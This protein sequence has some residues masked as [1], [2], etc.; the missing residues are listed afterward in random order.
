[1]K[2][3]NIII[4]IIILIIVILLAILTTFYF[5]E[6]GKYVYKIERVT[7]INYNIINKNERYG[8]I[9]RQGNIIVEPIYDIIQIPNPSKPIFICMSD[10]DTEAREYTIKVFNEKGEILYGEYNNIQAIPNETA[11]DGIPFEKT[12]LK[13]KM[14][15]KYGIISIDGK[16]ITEPIYDQIS[17]ISYK[18]GM[19]LVEQNETLGVINING[20]TL[21]PVEY[22]SITTDNY[23]SE[24]T[25]YQT[26]GFI[27]SQ[28][29]EDGY[30][31]GYI[32]YKGKKIVDTIYTE[33]ERV[34]EIQEDK[35]IY[36]V[37]IKDGQAGLL[38]N[39]QEILNYEYEDITYNLYNDVF[40]I[41]RNG[42]Q[43][44][45]NRQGECKIPV[46]YDN[47]LF[48]GIYVNAE[49]D[50]EITILDINGNIVED[51]N[52]LLK[53]PTTDGKHYIVSDKNEIY[54]IIDNDGNVVIDKGYSYIEEINKDYYIV[55]NGSLNGIIDLKGN[56]LVS[57]KYNSIFKLDGTDLLQANISET[58]AV[59]LINKD[60]RVIAGMENAGVEVTDKHIIIYS[61]TDT[62]Y[63]DYQGNELTNKQVYPNNELYAKKVDNKWG[64]VD[65]ND[66]IK[67]EAIYEIVTEFNEYG[68][69]GVR[70]NGK[71][72]V[73]DIQGNMV[74]E[75][76]YKLEWPNPE[77]IGK[78]YK[79]TEWYGDL[80]YTDVVEK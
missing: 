36:L 46:D 22:Y 6:R 28:K 19:L 64:F 37:A 80:Y 30:K 13:Y 14:N 59:A 49:K 11:S 43:G 17:S 60:M 26:T 50:E 65:K 38:K 48:G 7:E 21:I 35:N 5:I 2:K 77:F 52:I 74:Q 44:I 62:R 72:G 3:R 20:R 67:V 57:L 25:L 8:V 55:A 1:M 68:F 51:Q 41:Q 70:K 75:P 15:E 53:I 40:V 29:K 31:Y 73:I 45:V 63:F 12:V 10:Y 24:Q 71:W 27:V 79:Q 47:I 54:K 42:K 66:N 78:F 18:E 58:N 69:A 61:Y 39:K 16:K 33:I 23:Y 9:D 34:N 4:G 32:D 76:I 56:S